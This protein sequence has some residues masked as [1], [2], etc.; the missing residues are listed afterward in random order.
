M[1]RQDRE[2]K[3]LKDEARNLQRQVKRD[4]EIQRKL[5]EDLV[6]AQTVIREK[7][8]ALREAEMDMQGTMGGRFR[9][10]EMD[11]RTG[12]WMM[13]SSEVRFLP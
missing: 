3:L 12:N 11:D 1:L 10:D 8:L 9:R 4:D 2:L 6:Q 7:E 13:S 5:E